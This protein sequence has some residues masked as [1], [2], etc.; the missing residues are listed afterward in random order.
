MSVPSLKAIAHVMGGQVSGS[1]ACFPTPGHSKEDRGS[2][3]TIV[4]G[5]P[6][7]VLIHSSN[8]GDPIA[9]KKIL[10]DAGVLPP[11]GA[12]S[13]EVPWRAPTRHA[14]VPKDHALY[15]K[16]GQQIVATFNYV[17]GAGTVLYRKHRVEPG[18]GG[19][20]KTF[21][22]DRPDSRDG[23]KNG[24][25]ELRVPYR[26]PDLLSAPKN[27]PVYMTEG[28]AKADK[29]ANWGLL[30]TSYKDWREQDFAEFIR[31]R[32]IYIL[33]DNDDA[34]RSQRDDACA[35]M[36]RSGCELHVID[37]PR[38]PDG[39]DILDW[40]GTAD[41]LQA[42]VR[43][44]ATQ[45]AIQ[46]LDLTELA[47]RVPEG[48]EFAIFPLA[49]AGEVT[50]CTGKGSAGKSLL[51]Q[52]LATSA[53]IGKTTLGCFN[54]S[55]MTAVYV[56]CEDDA[57]EL[58]WR[59]KHICETMDISLESLAGRLHLASLRGQLGNELATFGHDSTLKPTP[60]YERLQELLRNTGAEIAFL[61]N[62]AHLFAGN[63]NDRHQVAAFINLLNRL[64]GDANIAIVLLGHPN[65]IGDN[66]SGSTAWIN[67]VRSHVFIEH[68]VDTDMRT[69][70]ISKANYARNGEQVRFFWRNWSFVSEAE[71][72]PEEIREMKESQRAA[73]DS[74][75]FLECLRQIASEG[76]N[77]SEKACQSYA[78]HVFSKMPEAKSVSKDRLE[79]AMNLLFRQK[80]IERAELRKGPDRKPVFGLRE[81]GAD[82]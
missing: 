40:D 14:E 28:E 55:P 73:K 8:G 64:A 15:L 34:G 3:A 23:W 69:L 32:R 50:L 17:D 41:E 30:A 29:L 44:V 56:T 75:I 77:V 57:R 5:A 68:D 4:H 12:R 58:H 72:R 70:T 49:P 27:M 47:K 7:G 82:V 51:A 13:N 24:A 35:K 39:G 36:K 46:T 18:E 71:M 11:L 45:D 25:G 33:P 60:T 66:Y 78:P 1:R 16:N 38:L 61:D 21:K 48:K 9:I 74:Q 62:I 10:R 52:Q 65:K 63:E 2:W 22:Y 67:Q 53:A 54:P 59:Q 26:L 43:Q 20:P 42:L 19:K 76:R 37:L 79:K 6:D 31:G 80:R 81:T